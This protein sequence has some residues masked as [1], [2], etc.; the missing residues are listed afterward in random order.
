MGLNRYGYYQ[1][2]V[3]GSIDRVF[4]FDIGIKKL[5]EITCDFDIQK[6]TLCSLC[7]HFTQRTFVP[8]NERV[9]VQGEPHSISWAMS[10]K[11]YS[12]N[13]PILSLY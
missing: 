5:P 12:K 2:G 11:K 3:A 1:C 13:A 10:Y 9:P 8:A 7:G 6:R 4:G